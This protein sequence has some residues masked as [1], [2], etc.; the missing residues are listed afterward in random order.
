MKRTYAIALSLVSIMLLLTA[1]QPTPATPPVVNK[2]DSQLAEI[3]AA[4]TQSAAPS[5]AI[6]N[7][8]A[9]NAALKEAL[10]K[11]LGAPETFA[12]AYKNKKGNVTVEINATVEVPA[13]ADIPAIEVKTRPFPQAEVDKFAAYFLKGAPVF[14]EKHVRTK[15][16]IMSRILQEKYF[17]DMITRSD[18]YKKHPRVVADLNNAKK[19]LEELQE[20]YAA[21]PEQRERTPSTTQLIKTEYGTELSVVAD[22]GKDAAAE[23]DAYS[24]DKDSIICFT[25][26][27]SGH[28]MPAFTSPYQTTL[29]RGMKTSLEDAKKTVTQCLAELGITDMQIQDTDISTYYALSGYGKDTTQNKQCYVFLLERNFHGIPVTCIAESTANDGDDPSI[30][31][32]E[33]P[34]Y[35]Y[36]V[37]A[38]RLEINVDDTGIIRFEW[39]NP[40]QEEKTLAAHVNLMNFADIVAKAKDYMF[41]KTY[42]DSRTKA[43]I[44]ITSIKLGMMRITQ[45]D[46]PGE[47]L[48]APVWDFIGNREQTVDNGS[49]EWLTFGDQS[50]VTVNAIDGSFIHR[51]WGY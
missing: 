29:P 14:K 44:H 6:S 30:P 38:E 8:P 2:G 7:D 19:R 15:A 16:E 45:K 48:M 34:N 28:Y 37:E 36:V 46:K 40:I 20:Q 22:L 47:Y 23:F 24:S 3:I 12:D 31:K 32:S 33:E 11:T 1:C 17:V 26:Y 39:H 49:P 50:Y 21:A 9:Q 10:L 41:Y 42:S 51:D 27:G 18:E 4:S 43:A 5:A 35:D 13:A 25:N